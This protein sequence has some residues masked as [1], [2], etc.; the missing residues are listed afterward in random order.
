MVQSYDLF[1]I[2]FNQPNIRRAF[3]IVFNP[4]RRINLI[5]VKSSFSL[6]SLP[7][8]IPLIDRKHRKKRQQFWKILL[9]IPYSIVY[10]PMYIF[11]GVMGLF[12]GI[13]NYRK[14]EKI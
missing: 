14:L 13:W 5:F 3:R 4:K 10:V 9:I 11:A 6:L 1:V 12:Q 8:V 2:I 7:Y